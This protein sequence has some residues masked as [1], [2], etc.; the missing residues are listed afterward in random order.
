MLHPESLLCCK[1]PRMLR[2]VSPM[3]IGRT[4]GHLL[5][6]MSWQATKAAN[7][8][9]STMQ[10]Q[11]R[12]A[13][14]ARASHRLINADLNEEHNRFLAAA[15]NPERSAAP[16]MRRTVL[17]I[18]SPSILSKRIGWSSGIWAVGVTM[19]DCFSGCFGG[20]FFN[21]ISWTV[22]DFTNCYPSSL[23]WQT[24]ELF[25]GLAQVVDDVVKRNGAVL[26]IPPS[27]IYER[28]LGWR[29]LCRHLVDFY[30]IVF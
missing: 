10:E 30:H 15:S 14:E 7:H 4:P 1:F 8:L 23:A 19:D 9:G 17:R 20:C 16:S 12:L 11:S 29:S 3:P 6:V 13:V 28:C 5:R 21:R 26:C 27:W 2:A 24:L 18:S 25:A 22:L